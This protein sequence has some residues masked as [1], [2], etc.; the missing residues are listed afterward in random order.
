MS[1]DRSDLL[2]KIYDET[3]PMFTN[4]MSL[5]IGGCGSGKSYMMYNVFLPMYAEHFNICHLLV[6][7]KTGE[8]DYTMT[9]AFKSFK[10]RFPHLSPR[11]IPLNT[12]SQVSQEI[13]A[14]AI[15]SSY[16]EKILKENSEGSINKTLQSMFEFHNSMGEYPIIKDALYIYFNKFVKFFDRERYEFIITKNGRRVYDDDIYS[17]DD[18]EYINSDDTSSSSLYLDADPY[19]HDNPHITPDSEIKI[20]YEVLLSLN[21]YSNPYVREKK[22]TQKIIENIHS[23]ARVTVNSCGPE[24]QPIL[25]IV[26]D[27]VGT[28]ALNNKNSPFTSLALVRRHLH[29]SIFILSQSCVGVNTTIRRNT[30]SFHLLPNISQVDLNYIRSYLPASISLEEL[31]E[32]YESNNLEDDRNQ[33]ITN[34]FCVYPYN[35]VVDGLPPSVVKYLYK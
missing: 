21:E 26:D 3:F 33:R 7:N 18:D 28:T 31:K 35:E 17:D 30:N 22:L 24:Y 23:F 12:L 2:Y 10:E 32:R 15:K 25:A 34:I 11:I 6:C 13:R 16:A 8:C 5:I 14:N 29:L 20:D 9:K 4:T 27:N 19:V 1:K